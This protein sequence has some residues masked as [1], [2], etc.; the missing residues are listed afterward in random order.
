ATRTAAGRGPRWT[1]ESA[2]RSASASRR[3]APPN[4]WTVGAPPPP[5]GRFLI[6]RVPDDYEGESRGQVSTCHIASRWWQ[7]RLG[8]VSDPAFRED[9][10]PSAADRPGPAERSAARAP[11]G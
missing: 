2:W 8:G 3:D 9:R 6:V 1:I 11:R 10:T 5:D 4:L 7:A